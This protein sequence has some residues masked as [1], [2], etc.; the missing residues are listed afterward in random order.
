MY[1]GASARKPTRLASSLGVAVRLRGLLPSTSTLHSSP[2]SLPSL[3]AILDTVARAPG[4]S[5]L[6]RTTSMGTTL[7]A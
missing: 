4:V 2:G 1:S 3:S 7:G 6:P 5:M